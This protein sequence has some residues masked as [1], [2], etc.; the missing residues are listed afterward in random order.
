[1]ISPRAIPELRRRTRVWF[2][3]ILAW[4][5][6]PVILLGCYW[7]ATMGLAAVGTS[8]EALLEGFKALTNS[9]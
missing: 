4:I 5:L 8:P 7:L 1:M 3:E 9:L 2:E 6:V